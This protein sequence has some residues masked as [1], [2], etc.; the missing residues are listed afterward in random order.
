MGEPCKVRR[1]N[2]LWKADPIARGGFEPPFSDPKSD[3]LPLDERAAAAPKGIGPGGTRQLTAAPSTCDES[4]RVRGPPLQ[5]IRST[6]AARVTVRVRTIAVSRGALTLPAPSPNT[7][8]TVEP[9]PLISA[10]SAP[11]RRSSPRYSSITEY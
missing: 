10:I 11:H 1:E 9:D 6:G 3:V 4:G 8:N 5:S 2:G 7:P